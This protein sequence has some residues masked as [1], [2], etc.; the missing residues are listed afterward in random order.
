MEKKGGIRQRILEVRLCPT[1]LLRYAQD[2]EVES[3]MKSIFLHHQ[4]NIESYPN[5]LKIQQCVDDLFQC[6]FRESIK[7]L[8]LESKAIEFLTWFSQGHENDRASASG[9]R[10][11]LLRNEDIAKLKEAKRLIQTH[12][13]DPL[14]IRQLSG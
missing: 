2:D 5:N 4:G 7:R 12:I 14:S 3:M 1:E 9:A 8:Y 11:F 10:A 13:D 6:T